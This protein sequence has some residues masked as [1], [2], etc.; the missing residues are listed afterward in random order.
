MNRK[1]ANKGGRVVVSVR[2]VVGRLVRQVTPPPPMP[3]SMTLRID[4]DCTIP[5][6]RVL[7]PSSSSCI[8]SL[9]HGLIRRIVIIRPGLTIK[10]TELAAAVKGLAAHVDND[11]LTELLTAFGFDGRNNPRP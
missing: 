8:R 10:A 6:R 4:A 1:I 11:E 5:H 9:V 2:L 3:P 7:V